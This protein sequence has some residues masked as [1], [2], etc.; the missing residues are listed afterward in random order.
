MKK[1]LKKK[2]L[3][4]VKNRVIATVKVDVVG[5]EEFKDLVI[6]TCEFVY[7]NGVDTETFKANTK[8]LLNELGINPETYAIRSD[9]N[10]E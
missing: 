8:Y 3:H 9:V 2:K 7:G 1:R 5:I 10:E 4:Q 6:S